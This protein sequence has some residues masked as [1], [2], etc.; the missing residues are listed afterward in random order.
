MAVAQIHPWQSWDN[1][2]QLNEQDGFAKIPMIIGYHCWS[3]SSNCWP[4]PTRVNLYHLPSLT[5]IQ[6]HQP[7]LNIIIMI[8]V[9]HSLCMLIFEW[10]WW[11]FAH[12]IAS[13]HHIA[14]PHYA[15][16]WSCSQADRLKKIWAEQEE[17]AT[18][19]GSGVSIGFRRVCHGGGP[20]KRGVL[21]SAVSC[22]FRL[23]RINTSRRRRTSKRVLYL[24]I[25]N[26]S[27]E[28]S[29]W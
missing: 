17:Q 12:R 20:P 11:W 26:N 4:L 19:E 29:S 9:N 2:D 21:N 6:C 8:I 3:S 7:W 14:Q 23:K 13:A 28:F 24:W 15:H 27:R 10:L 22:R 5:T 16:C 25:L 1:F 18:S